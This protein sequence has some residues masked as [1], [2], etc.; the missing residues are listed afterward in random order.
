MRRG[1][2]WVLSGLTAGLVAC[3][4]DRADLTVQRVALFEDG[5]MLEVVASCADGAEAKVVEFGGDRV[6]IAVTGRARDEDCAS[7]TVLAL[8]AEERAAIE[9]GAVLETADGQQL[10]LAP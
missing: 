4:A 3:S 10:E 7:S 5:W 6:V 8:S 2:A 1:G 9:A